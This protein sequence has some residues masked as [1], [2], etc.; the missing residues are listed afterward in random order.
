MNIPQGDRSR[1]SSTE[2][3]TDGGSSCAMAM[4]RDKPESSIAA[5]HSIAVPTV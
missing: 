3:W 5:A 1:G 2:P 4:G